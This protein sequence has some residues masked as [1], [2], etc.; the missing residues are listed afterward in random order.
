MSG[1]VAGRR[2]LGN[3]ASSVSPRGGGQ[4]GAR[5]IKRR[6][7]RRERHEIR[8]GLREITSLS[9][10]RK[11][12][13]VT[14]GPG[15]GPGLRLTVDPEGGNV[16]GLCGLVTCGSVWACPVCAAKVAARRADELA[17]VMRFALKRG[18]TATMVTLT[19]RHHKGQRLKDCWDAVSG[20]WHAVT[21]GK[22]WVADSQV[23]GLKAG[24]GS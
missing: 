23:F 16:A 20:G 2:P 12:G 3:R 22:Q 8:G 7:R 4:P 17:D 14:T 21:S 15:G 10:V 9:R 11:C 18:C 13:Y 19:M 24:S 5:E 1:R 6:K